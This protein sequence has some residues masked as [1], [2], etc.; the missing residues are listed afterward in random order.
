VKG[1]PV[2]KHHERQGST[3][4]GAWAP[5]AR[6]GIGSPFVED[7]GA[8]RSDVG[9]NGERASQVG[10]NVFRG[11]DPGSHL[12]QCKPA[13]RQ[14]ENRPLGDVEDILPLLQRRLSGQPDL[15][16]LRAAWGKIPSRVT[17]AKVLLTRCR[18]SATSPTVV[19]AIATRPASKLCGGSPSLNAARAR[20]TR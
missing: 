11:V 15:L 17:C 8:H 12:D 13:R 6:R 16:D 19:R 9:W 10:Q 20:R 1:I 5:A 3:D 18:A 14:S 2:R 4:A 7:G